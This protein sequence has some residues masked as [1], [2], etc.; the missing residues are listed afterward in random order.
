M[1][2]VPDLS[3]LSISVGSVETGSPRLIVGKASPLCLIFTNRHVT[4]IHDKI[5]CL[6]VWIKRD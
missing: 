1:V 3:S 4:D 5:T 2:E 6:H